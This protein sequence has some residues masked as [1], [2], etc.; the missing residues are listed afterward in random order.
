MA[1]AIA[2]FACSDFLRRAAGAFDLHAARA[3]WA[4]LLRAYPENCCLV[5]IDCRGVVET[6]SYA[7]MYALLQEIRA[8]ERYFHFR[9][10]LLYRP[11]EDSTRA[12]FLA[13]LG[14]LA[15]LQ[16]RLFLDSE[17]AE[18]W[19]RSDDET[20]PVADLDGTARDQSA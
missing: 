13:Y 4:E 3:L 1:D 15:G 20:F 16:I 19:L 14:R 8:D 6:G 2:V 12:D 7:D 11:L 9:I 10:G 5:L 18:I 17:E